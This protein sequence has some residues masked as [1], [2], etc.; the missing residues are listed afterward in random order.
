MA[1]PRRLGVAM[2]HGR[3]RMVLKGRESCAT[4]LHRWRGLEGV[5]SLDHILR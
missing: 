5:A 1:C 2:G 4:G 3:A